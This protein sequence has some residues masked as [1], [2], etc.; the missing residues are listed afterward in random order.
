MKVTD[1]EILQKHLD[2]V[3][4]PCWNYAGRCKTFQ[5]E[6]LNAVTGLGGEAGEIVDQVKKM[7]FHTEKPIE[8]HREKLKHEFGDSFF[9][10]LKAMELLGITIEEVLAANREKLQSRHPELG[11]V[12]ERFGDGY[13]K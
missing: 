4:N 9:Y 7:C 12:Q 13:I 6:L 10:H 1:V 11:L 8:F 5:D 2:E 3:I